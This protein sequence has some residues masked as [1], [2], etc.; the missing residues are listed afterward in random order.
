MELEK[1]GK[2][3]REYEGNGRILLHDGQSSS[4]LIN[5][6]QL[7]D[8]KIRAKCT[9]FSNMN[10]VI[11]CYNKVIL[12]KSVEGTTKE[13]KDFVLEGNIGYKNISPQLNSQDSTMIIT[14]G[15]LRVYK[16]QSNVAKTIKFGIT[17]LEYFGNK[18]RDI[19]GGGWAMD[20]LSVNI[21]ETV[22]EIHEV[23]NYKSIIES[24]N[25]QRNIDVTCEAV[26]N[27]TSI[28]DIEKTVS[29][30]GVLC[31]LLSLARGTKINWIYYD[32]YDTDGQLISSFHDNN[33]VW[34]FA[35]LPLIDLRNPTETKAFLEQ[36][37]PSYNELKDKYGLA[38]GIE[39][40]LDAKREG[41]Y[42]ETRA[43]IASVLL[44]FLSDKYVGQDNSFKRNLEIMLKKLEI[45]IKDIELSR[46]KNTRNSLAH[47]TSFIGNISGK[48]VEDY[49]DL[50]GIL[51]KVFLKILNYSGVY[52][53]ITNKYER[54]SL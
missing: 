32:C 53:D 22:I 28:T 8:G 47:T 45:P 13:D 14:A 54:T 7:S 25:A 31:K 48:H 37:F 21:G 2:I 15:R 4:C 9:S 12:I 26:I 11:D 1:Y 52:L 35:P 18:R 40:Y 16:K 27:I 3:I 34:R 10:L 50:I 24:I 6:T 51:D 39:A 49:C 17:N 46:F 41:V 43:L 33:V 36:V 42:L 29:V 19:L 38:F 44:E 5:V 30:I 23:E 20:I